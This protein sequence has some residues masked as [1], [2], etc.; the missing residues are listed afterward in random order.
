M[1][2]LFFGRLIKYR[3]FYTTIKNFNVRQEGSR[4][5]EEWMRLGFGGKVSISWR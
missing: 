4:P 1:I 5:L 2:K 3:N